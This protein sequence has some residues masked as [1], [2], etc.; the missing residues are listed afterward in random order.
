M[1]V[2]GFVPRRKACLFGNVIVSACVHDCVSSLRG[3]CALEA[4]VNKTVKQTGWT[5]VYDS[6]RFRCGHL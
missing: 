3:V 2:T 1:P 5:N 6:L 4:S